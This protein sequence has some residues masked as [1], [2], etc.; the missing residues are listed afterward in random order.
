MNVNKVIIIGLDGATWDIIIPWANKGELPTFKKL[1]ENGVYGDLRSTVP[2]ATIP[3]WPSFATGANPGKHGLFDFLKI[4]ENYEMDMVL[5]PSEAIKK[6]TLWNI[7]SLADKRVG[8]INIPTTYPPKPVNGY[9]ITGMLTS[10]DNYTFPKNLKNKLKEK[11]GH[12]FSFYSESGKNVDKFF[13]SLI[14]QLEQRTEIFLDFMEKDLDFLMMVDNGTDRVQHECWKYIDK[15]NPLYNGQNVRKH[16]NPILRY[17]K[18]VDKFLSVVL[19]K[20][21]KNTILFLMSDHGQGSLRKFININSFLIDEGYMKI[22]KNLVS[23]LRYALFK[24]GFS[25][26]NVYQF[27][28]IFGI[29]RKISKE[30]R[31]KNRISLAN[32]FF[33]SSRDIDWKKTKAFASGVTGGIRLNVKGREKHGIVNPG[34]EYDDLREGIIKKLEALKDQKNGKNVVRFAEK[35][36][37]IYSGDYVGEAPDV[38]ATAKGYYE[39]F[40]MHGFTFNKVIEDTF[41][42]SGKHTPEGIILLYSEQLKG[43]TKIEGASIMDI[44]PTVLYVLDQKIPDYIDGK[45]LE[46]VFSK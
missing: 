28:R 31:R 30:M 27:L 20:M 39:F 16:G 36:E 11:Y 34:N 4:N 37:S 29:E 22:K 35:R 43:G 1:L 32:R 18:H 14:D 9:M 23:S 3:A 26:K 8:L 6:A 10:S 7:L 2:W 13:N 45:I 15:N 25:P 12:D 21:D 24:A 46:K 19:N 38:I 17:Y 5:K 41:V 33:F 40:G 44:F 42:N